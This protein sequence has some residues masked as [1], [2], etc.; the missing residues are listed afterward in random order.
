[1]D[2]VQGQRE[3]CAP[4]ALRSG[5][6][7]RGGTQVLALGQLARLCQREAG[8]AAEE[9]AGAVM[10]AA[11]LSRTGVLGRMAG[12]QQVSFERVELRLGQR[13]RF[14]YGMTGQRSSGARQRDGN[15]EEGYRDESRNG[16]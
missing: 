13:L 8:D 4:G 3:R 15:R 16:A 12:A 5:V 1:M 7:G 6:R 10:F 14:G 11:P 9:L 2:R